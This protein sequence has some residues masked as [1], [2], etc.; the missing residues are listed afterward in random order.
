MLCFLRGQRLITMELKHYL[1]TPLKYG[2]IVKDYLKV[3]KEKT[4]YDAWTLNDQL[5]IV[6]C[7]G[8]IENNGS[9]NYH[10]NYD[11]S[12]NEMYVIIDKQKT[13]KWFSLNKEDV[14]KVQQENI[15]KWKNMLQ[16]E[17]SRLEVI[18]QHSI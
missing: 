2:E 17:L 14:I 4:E 11:D 7:K 9:W 13:N 12:E 3:L 15:L 16:E 8:L 10:N 18:S 6:K 1:S 5:E